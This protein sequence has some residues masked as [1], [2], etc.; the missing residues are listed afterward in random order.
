M[1]AP[2]VASS[3]VAPVKS[4]AVTIDRALSMATVYEFVATADMWI[5]QRHE[6]EKGDV[7]AGRRGS[8]FVPKG[9]VLTLHGHHGSIVSVVRD[10]ADGVA[11]LTQLAE[12]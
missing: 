8:M 12:V 6:H 2:L 4:T 3:V 11:V 1:L 5:R 9:R 7:E 10:K